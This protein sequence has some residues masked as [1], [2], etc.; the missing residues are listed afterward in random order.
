MVLE[1]ENDA[2]VTGY[3]VKTSKKG[4]KY[5]LVYILGDTGETFNCLCECEIPDNFKPL[6]KYKVRFRVIPGRYT[7]LKVVG[8]D[9]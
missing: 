5:T 4:T 1:F 2:L 3:D 6:K 9:E 7:Q 8:F